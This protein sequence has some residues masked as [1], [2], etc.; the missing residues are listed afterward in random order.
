M[1]IASIFHNLFEV[2]LNFCSPAEVV[3]EAFNA[4]HIRL[5]RLQ[6]FQV[7]ILQQEVNRSRHDTHY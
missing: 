5:F 4:D 6:S 7:K 3:V 2:E 1:K